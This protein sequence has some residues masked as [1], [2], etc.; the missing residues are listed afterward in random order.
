MLIDLLS[1]IGLK[2][3]VTFNK[4]SAYM[5]PTLYRRVLNSY[6]LSIVIDI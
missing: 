2:F 3:V 6:G 1:K 4:N 5:V